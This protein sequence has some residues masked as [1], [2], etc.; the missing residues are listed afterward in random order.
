MDAAVMASRGR[1]WEI[2]VGALVSA[3]FGLF[4][5]SAY[6][7]AQWS[8]EPGYLISARFSQADGIAVG[9]D[10]WLSGIAVGKVVDQYLDEYNE[11]VLVMRIDPNIELDSEASAAVV[12]DGLFGSKFV[13]IEVGGGET[14]IGPG[15]EISYTESTMAIDDLLEM[16]LQRARANIAAPAPAP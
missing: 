11:A 14:I 16:I 5:V 4:V 7:R 10:V 3:L 13:Q 15:G 8:P 6:T 12:T 9:G 1:S 2:A